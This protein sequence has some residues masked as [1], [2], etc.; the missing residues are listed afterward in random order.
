VSVVDR[1]LQLELVRCASL[2]A[3]SHNTQCWRFVLED[4]AILVQPD[5]ARRCPAVD[6]DDHHLYASLGCATENLVQAARAQGLVPDV[7]VAESGVVRVALAPGDPVPSPLFDAI[8]E[9]Q[10][11]R[12]EYDGR[13]VPDASLR[14]LADAGTAPGVR[15]LLMTDREDLQHILGFVKEASAQQVGDAG[16]VEELKRW[17]RFNEQ[18]TERTCDGLSFRCTG[19]PPTAPWLG[20]LLFGFYFTKGAESEKLARQLLS[21]AGV[22]IFVSDEND[23]Q[24][25]VEAGR[26][27]QRFALQATALGVRHAFVNQP[28]E[29]PSVRT[30]FAAWLGVGRR[31]PDLMVRF[32]FGPAMPR[33]LRRPVESVL[34]QAEPRTV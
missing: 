22:A 12:T 29:V 1:A 30:A 21:S 18:E 31:R 14:L 28:V 3:S 32:G 4:D 19:H 34:A 16:F 13:P 9:R 10:C 7:T 23:R 24:H 20:R 2:A 15:V 26:A 27:Y 6:P 33:S 8:A 25:W 11:S 5:P 17:I